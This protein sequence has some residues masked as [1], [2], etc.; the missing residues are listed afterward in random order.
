MSRAENS[1]RTPTSLRAWICSMIFYISISDT[2]FFL[3][4]CFDFIGIGPYL[5]LTLITVCM[6][7][8]YL[9]CLM[10]IGPLWSRDP[11]LVCYIV[12]LWVHSWDPWLRTLV[13]NTSDW[14]HYETLQI[15]TSLLF[16]LTEVIKSEV[17]T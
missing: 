9:V 4:S 3:Q 12:A 6:L 17:L 1:F 16:F 8:C 10:S 13:W 5:F 2:I 15:S 11:F 7:S 14:D